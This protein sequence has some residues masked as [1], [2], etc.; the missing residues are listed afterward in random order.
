MQEVSVECIYADTLNE[1]L[2]THHGKPMFILTI[3]GYWQCIETGK[4]YD[5]DEFC[6]LAR[7]I[8]E[9]RCKY[10]GAKCDYYHERRR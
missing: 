10:E 8:I 5:E 1:I 9:R 7:D 2:T 4:E 3:E 6:K